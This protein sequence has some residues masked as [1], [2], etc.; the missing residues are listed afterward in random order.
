MKGMI[1]RNEITLN[2]ATLC[3]IVEDWLARSSVLPDSQ[4]PAVSAVRNAGNNYHFA[5][6]ERE[7]EED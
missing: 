7:H 5:L 3:E 6:S 4:L 1:G 2:A